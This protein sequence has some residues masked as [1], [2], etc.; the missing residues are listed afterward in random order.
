MNIN[1]KYFQSF[2]DLSNFC[3]PNTL[4]SQK[5]KSDRQ[6]EVNQ[7]FSSAGKDQLH[8]FVCR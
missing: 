8:P 1:M 6:N 4:N 5:I 2:D 3:H 7:T